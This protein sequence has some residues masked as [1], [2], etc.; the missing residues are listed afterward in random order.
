MRHI[1]R[2]VEQQVELNRVAHFY[3][4]R[5]RPHRVGSWRRSSRT[6][7]EVIP[8]GDAT[9]IDEGQLGDCPRCGRPVI[10]G[11]LGFGCSGWRKGCPF[12]L[13]REYKGHELGDDQIRQLLQRHVLLEPITFGESREVVLQLVDKGELTE[14]PIPVGGQGA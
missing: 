7:G 10:A 6:T 1:G 2:C 13:W 9:S 5:G 14:I 8:C 3:M 11:K 4:D 12:V